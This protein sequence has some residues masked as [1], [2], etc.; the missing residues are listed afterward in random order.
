MSVR[1]TWEAYF[2]KKKKKLILEPHS[3]K[4]IVSVG[5]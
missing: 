1:I 2:E 5:L 4:N 3:Q